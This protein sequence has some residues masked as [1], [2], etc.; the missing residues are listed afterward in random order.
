MRTT[1]KSTSHQISILQMGPVPWEQDDRVQNEQSHV[2][3]VPQVQQGE[4]AIH[5]SE[6]ARA[7]A[8]FITSG[9]LNSAVDTDS[10]W[11]EGRS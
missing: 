9:V 3:E 5:L 11:P 1:T 4:K 10:E 2:Q 6:Y 8:N 7:S